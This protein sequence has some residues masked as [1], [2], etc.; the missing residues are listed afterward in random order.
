VMKYR[1]VELSLK[2]T[3]NMREWIFKG[4]PLSILRVL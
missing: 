1:L 4:Y 2:Q 3:Q